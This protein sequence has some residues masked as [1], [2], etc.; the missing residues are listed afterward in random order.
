[1][2]NPIKASDLYQ[3]DGA[4]EAAI[5]Q[6]K[7]LQATYEALIDSTRKDAVRLEVEVKKMASSTEGY[8]DALQKAAAKADELDK[9]HRDFQNA[10]KGVEDAIKK[11][12]KAQDAHNEAIAEGVEITAEVEKALE[13][14]AKSLDDN[15]VKLA[16]VRLATQKMNQLNKLEAKLAMAKA[17]SYNALSAQY[18]ILKIKL[19]DMTEAERKNTA[20]GQEMEKQAK[21]IYEKMK[22]LQA[23]TGKTSLNVGNY[24][25]A[26]RNALASQKDFTNNLSAGNI[27]T[28]AYQ[29]AIAKLVQ[30]KVAM[31]GAVKGTISPLKAFR[32]ALASTGIGAIVV[33]IGA[34][35]SAFLSTQ[36]GADAVTRVLTPLKTVMQG[37]IG[38]AQQVSFWF[39]DKIK[40]AFENPRQAIQDL[41]AAIKEF[42]LDRLRGLAAFGPAIARILSGEVK[43]GFQD[44]A[45][46]A[47]DA[48]GASLILNSELG[49][50]VSTSWQLGQ[51]IDALRK[52]LREEEIAFESRRAELERNIAA[53][54][55]IAANTEETAQR[56][57]SALR[58]AQAASDQLA[59]GEEK[60]ARLRLQLAK[61]EASVNDTNAEARLE[62]ARLQAELTKVEADNL[63][64]K[65]ELIAQVASI[66][67]EA[68]NRAAADAK[69]Q[70]DAVKKQAEEERKALEEKTKAQVA[71][72]Q[73]VTDLRRGQ[74]S[75]AEQTFQRETQALE[76]T[77]TEQLAIAEKYGLS[78]AALQDAIETERA[79]IRKRYEEAQRQELEDR[80]TRE[81]Q[82]EWETFEQEQE[83]AAARLNLTQVS[84]A[85][86]T[87]F[88]LE[89][90]KTKL[91]KML[92]LNAAYQ[93]DLTDL[94]IKTIEA[95]IDAIDA[96]LSEPGEGKSVL[97]LLGLNDQEQGV[98][99]DAF[100]FA[101][102]QLD[103][104]IAKRTEAANQAVQRSDNEVQAA[105]AALQAE[106]DAAAQGYAAN[107]DRARKELDLAKQN[108]KKA[109]DEQRRAQRAQQQIQ[110]AAQAAN[111]ITAS[112]KILGDFKLPFALLALSVMWGAFAAAQVK[113]GQ[114]TKKKYAQGGFEFLDYG[115]SHASGD[116]NPLGY[117]RDGKER[118]AERGEAFAVFNR[119]A[120]ARY[121]GVLPGLVDAINQ[122]RLER[123]MPGLDASGLSVVVHNTDMHRT[124][125]ELE[126]I[127]RQG[128]RKIYTDARGRTIELYRNKKTIYHA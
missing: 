23:A 114:L 82:A 62:I 90:E 31:A 11:T 111:L 79:A 46:A 106:I 81:R 40:A 37:L 53:D 99:K 14:Y 57:V 3:D 78:V 19:N 71:F 36:R 47:A 70:A 109:L 108:Q 69:A 27:A 49:N 98:I 45:Q 39:A 125:R 88:E 113:A 95:Q 72:L 105:Q 55:A 93:G 8:A 4:I 12:E 15:E 119:R 104:F 22:D 112:S 94:Q 29:F 83:L 51:A 103:E 28:R 68:A 26:I 107:V 38:A 86:R 16:A 6:L 54:R 87:R 73:T 122:G 24:E 35:V 124:E 58:R 30:V 2:A 100:A 110:A 102:S 115:G 44:L 118:R 21:E 117:T 76:Q 63:N 75:Q 126:Q 61:E 116:D 96:K 13:K 18:S 80:I 60:L 43:A 123:K 91:K 33:A 77:Y 25:E 10:A 65:R 128:E 48:T 5:T 101:K 7:S 42:L 20:A 1:M 17:G 120:T 121:R 74:L 52:Q 84:E 85:E 59:A 66:N 9:Q 41:G 32:L 67:K 97:D 50:V 127:R 92:E 34:L 56:R 89:A 64:R